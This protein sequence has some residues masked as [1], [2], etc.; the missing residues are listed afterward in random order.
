MTTH[1]K[2]AKTARAAVPGPQLFRLL[3]GPPIDPDEFRAAVFA[4]RGVRAR[5]WPRQGGRLELACD[6][7]TCLVGT[8]RV[9]VPVAEAI[10]N[11]DIDC[12]DG[13]LR[14]EP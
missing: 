4:D 2:K 12:H 5:S 8:V 14:G 3:E 6:N 13:Q 9:E 11:I 1:L 7:P 10:P